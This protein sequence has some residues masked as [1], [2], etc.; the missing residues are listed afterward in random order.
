VE[1]NN[2]RKLTSQHN[3]FQEHHIT[4]YTP[5]EETQLLDDFGNPPFVK[6]I[7]VATNQS[8]LLN[9]S[10]EGVTIG[11]R[12]VLPNTSPPSS[13]DDYWVE[14]NGNK[15]RVNFSHYETKSFGFKL[16]LKGD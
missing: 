1:L 6:E 15:K 4:I 16:F 9:P 8:L 11:Y 14:I 7:N 10:W 5:D 13:T 2:L 12:A 3:Q